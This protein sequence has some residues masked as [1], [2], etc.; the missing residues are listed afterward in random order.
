MYLRIIKAKTYF[1]YFPLLM[2]NYDNN[3]LKEYS[4]GKIDLKWRFFRNFLC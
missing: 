2:Q 1:Q 3:L 4:Q